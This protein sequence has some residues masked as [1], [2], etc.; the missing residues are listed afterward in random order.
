M[1]ELRTLFVVEAGY[2][3]GLGHLLRCRAL[4]L[5]LAARGH[6]ADL[7]LR[8]DE[9]ALA[10]R[11][12]PANMRLF[13]SP[14]SGS[15]D[16]ACEGIEKLLERNS[17]DWLI[18]DGYGISGNALCARLVAHGARLLMIDDLA[19]REFKADILL[20]QN[21]THREPYGNGRISA[22]RFLMGP[23]YALIDRSYALRRS[24]PRAHGELRNVL[25]SFGGVDRHGRTQRVLNLVSRHGSPLDIVAVVGP[26]YPYLDQL[27]F[28]RGRHALRVVRNVSD[29]AQLMRQ[30][31]LMVMAGGS[32]VWQGCCVGVPM[33][34]LRTVENQK[35]LIQTLRESDAALCLD[36]SARPNED[37]G[38]REDEFMQALRQAEMAPV[39]ERLAANAMRLVDGNGPGRVADAVES[40]V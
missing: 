17:Y 3:A 4:L 27:E 29:L 23:S 16:D 28:R 13:V 11:E 15:V 14:E 21:T 5:E 32:T 40:H 25:V 33:L 22:S 35:L 20:N 36:V 37:A 38:I 1:A 8:G 31:D 39:R 9:K 10:G 19:D 18:V 12:W 2:Q 26:Y 7:W 30:C 24:E 6:R 34:V